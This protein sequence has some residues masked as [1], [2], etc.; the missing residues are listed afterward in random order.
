VRQR[1]RPGHRYRPRCLSF[2]TKNDVEV[3]QGHL[4][5][6][7]PTDLIGKIDVL[8]AVVPYV[9]TDEIVF[10]PR[11]VRRYEPHAALHGG[12][13]GIELLVQAIAASARLLHPAGALVLEL[14][15]SQDKLVGPALQ[16]A[17]FDLVERLVDGEGD[18]RG[19]HA[20][21]ASSEVPE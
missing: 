12:E 13:A 19:I 2:V 8:V 6:P 10:L 7:I 3:Y 5:D 14:A 15:G 21:L 17:G 18:L 16:A 20:Q 4:A 11:D 1:A 9:P